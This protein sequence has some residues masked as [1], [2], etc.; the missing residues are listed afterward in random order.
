MTP[1]LVAAG[2]T[3]TDRAVEAPLAIRRDSVARRIV[4]I[5][6]AGTARVVVAPVMA[7]IALLVRRG[8]PGPAV[9]R[10][11]RVG[12]GE[13]PFTLL[14]F[15]SMRADGGAGAS[16]VSGRQDPRITRVGAVLRATKL[17]ELPQLVN[18]LRGD[19]TVIGPRAEVERYVAHYTDEERLLLTV[20]PGLTCP[21][22]LH[23]TEHQADELDDETDPETFYVEQ[24]LHPKLALDLDYLR[25]RSLPTD[26][27]VLWWTVVIL[28]RALRPTRRP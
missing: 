9:F 16:Q 12:V 26:L 25:R 5:V 27:G 1:S 23:F 2:A 7:V 14:K 15:R 17:D 24:Q 22:Q 18:V 20:R 21:G 28:L 6:I 4:D 3:T 11:V 10:Q 19:M 13:R 8:S